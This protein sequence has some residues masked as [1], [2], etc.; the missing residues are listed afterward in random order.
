MP[1]YKTDGN[2]KHMKYKKYYKPNVTY[3]G[4]G[5]ENETYLEFENKMNFFKD[6][7]IKKRRRERYSVDYFLNYK[8]ESLLDALNYYIQNID[9]SNIE[10]PVLIN[11]NS[12]T[13]TDINNNAR[14]LYTKLC[15][16]NPLFNDETMFETLQKKNPF[17][18]DSIDNK[19]LFD[20]DTIEFNT[21]EFFNTKLVDVIS[22]LNNNK[23]EF[24][25]EFNNTFDNEIFKHLNQYGKVKIM[26]QNHPFATYLTNFKNVT[27]FNNGTLHY[28]ITLPTELDKNGRIKDI[29]R[30]IK[31][32][33]KAIKIIQWMEPFLISI[34]G[35]PDPFSLMDNY[36]D[37]TNFSKSSQ[38]C[39]ISRY[40]GI[41]TYNSDEM[42][43]G[44]ILTKNINEILSSKTDK[45]WF[46][47]Y[48]KNNAYEQLNEIGMD[49][50]FNK[51]YNH[52]I[53]LRFFDHIS[54]EKILFESFEF[55]IYLMD[56]IL[57]SD[58][59][60]TFGN[61]IINMQWNQ[62]VL[63]SLIYGK[64]YIL[65]YDEKNVYECIFNMKLLKKSINDIYYEIYKNL[66]QMY[67][68]ITPRQEDEKIFKFE[69]KGIFSCNSLNILYKEYEVPYSNENSLPSEPSIDLPPIDLPPID[70]PPIDLPSID[71]PSI[72]LPSID[73]PSIDLPFIDLPPIDLP[74]I[75]L[76]PIDLPP[77]DLPPIDLP[78]IDLPSIDLPP[79]DLPPIDLP[80]IDLPN[81]INFPCNCIIS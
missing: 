57:E 40:I 16:P 33:S 37:K 2:E 59:I 42:P 4:L 76:P 55:I 80:P 31:E 20:G 21:L 64:E 34:Y 65:T 17:F 19:W 11:A 56:Y 74:S 72:D 43:K 78:S 67:N 18:I 39:A 79:I 75:D 29:A 45:W 61:P 66:V 10:M 69:P 30:F 60:N 46:S 77:I 8:Q 27:M 26:E 25:N 28:N 3:W 24:L 14:T 1:K 15:E 35:S 53:E 7:L 44:K 22:E 68:N 71:L 13:K 23:C 6:V 49:I 12:F 38:R 54:D 52:G 63:N 81:K 58:F 41:G 50:N 36:I 9:S 48:Y 73:L 62:V 70:L 47:E 51:H 32:H 5:I